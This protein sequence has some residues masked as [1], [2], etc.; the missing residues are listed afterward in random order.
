MILKGWA[1]YLE[2]IRAG[3]C[4]EYVFRLV[5]EDLFLLKQNLFIKWF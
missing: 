5:S 1:K 2:Q 4:C 3:T